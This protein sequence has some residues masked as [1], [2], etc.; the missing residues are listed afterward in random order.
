MVTYSLFIQQIIPTLNLL[1]EPFPPSESI[2]YFLEIK[3]YYLLID[4]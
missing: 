1:G 4:L 2:S 3:V